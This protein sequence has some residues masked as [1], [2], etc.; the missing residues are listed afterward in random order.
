MADPRRR[1]ALIFGGRSPEH[2]VS[3]VSA[4]AV[5]AALPA[6]R[7]QVSA[8]GITRTGR[9]TLADPD[10]SAW[11]LRGEQ[12]PAVPADGPALE[13]PAGPGSPGPL[14]AADVAFP[15]LHGPYGEDGTV[16]GLL[17]LAGVPYVGSGVLASAVT[18]FK[19]VMRHL[20]AAADLP[21]CPYR[22][23]PPGGEPSPATAAAELGY[24]LYVKPASG[25]SSIG[26]SRVSGPAELDAAVTLARS[27]DA[28]VLLEA[29]VR[30][31]EIECGV[32]EEAGELS[33]SP[34]GEVLV[35]PGR[36]FYDFT[37]KYLSRGTRLE[38]PARLSVAEA[39]AVAE[40]TRRA[41]RAL[42]CRGLARVDFFLA[43]D[44]LVVNEVN[45]MPGFTPTSMYPRMW[46]AAGVDYAALVARLLDGALAARGAGS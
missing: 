39:A 7:Y 37:A 17:E 21:V 4:G 3:C 44:R 13:M 8:I 30:G 35:E 32:L 20:L 9:W 23:L 29:E 2:G 12:L 42:G 40:H 31:R 11:Q 46:A 24:P 1:L 38:T 41:F 18:Q 25:G 10:P 45:T 36:P 6:E 19:P 27:L 5:L 43:A 22:V 26:I 33:T 34:P 14:G 16:Q 15:L 28:T